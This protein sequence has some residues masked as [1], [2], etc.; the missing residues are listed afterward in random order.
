MKGTIIQNRILNNQISKKAKV[1]ERRL[2][3]LSHF[4]Y[5]NPLFRPEN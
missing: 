3:A 5:V 1:A 4:L 2:T